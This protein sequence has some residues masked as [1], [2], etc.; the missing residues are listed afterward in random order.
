MSAFAFNVTILFVTAAFFILYWTLFRAHFKKQFTKPN[1]VSVHVPLP[2]LQK[3]YSKKTVYGEIRCRQFS[4]SPRQQQNSSNILWIIFIP[5]HGDALDI[6]DTLMNQLYEKLITNPPKQSYTKINMISYDRIGY[7]GSSAFNSINGNKVCISPPTF[8]SIT[9][10]DRALELL[11]FLMSIEIDDDKFKLFQHDLI[12]IGHSYGGL[13]AQSFLNVLKHDLKRYYPEVADKDIYGDADG[14]IRKTIKLLLMDTSWIGMDQVIGKFEVTK[15][16][17]YKDYFMTLCGLQ[18]P[19]QFY[20]YP[21]F[22]YLKSVNLNYENEIVNNLQICLYYRA[23]GD[24]IISEWN[25]SLGFWQ[26]MD[27]FGSDI[28]EW[29]NMIKNMKDENGINVLIYNLYSKSMSDFMKEVNVNWSLFQ[30][31]LSHDIDSNHLLSNECID[32]HHYIYLEKP[33][34][35]LNSILSLI[36]QK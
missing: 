15:Y 7:G 18:P 5:G 16:E 27:M 31:N 22:E 21:T 26:S 2:H 36:N 3:S 8:T 34:V 20:K 33:Q 19:T 35:V 29:G 28:K 11:S 30:K 23:Y 32:C 13:I 17:C 6:Y 12:L 24:Q 9:S 25:E 10:H 4:L 1:D 14:N